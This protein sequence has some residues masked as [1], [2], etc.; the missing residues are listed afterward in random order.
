MTDNAMREGKLWAFLRDS[1]HEAYKKLST[2]GTSCEYHA[3]LDSIAAK[4]ADDVDARF[5]QVAQ[6]EQSVPVEVFDSHCNYASFAGRV[7]NKCGRIH[8]GGLGGMVGGE[9]V[10]KAEEKAA[11]ADE[12]RK[13]LASAEREREQSNARLHEVAVA[14]ATAE[15][16]RDDAHEIIDQYKGMAAR[17]KACMDERDELRKDAEKRDAR[18]DRH[19]RAGFMDGWNAGVIGDESALKAAGERL[20]AAIAQGQTK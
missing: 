12:L 4:V 13:K 18:E 6:S 15:R 19:W 2:T 7:C 9:Q 8:D 16:E 11:E 14:C 5:L 10:S 17:Y 1:I 20:D 3:L